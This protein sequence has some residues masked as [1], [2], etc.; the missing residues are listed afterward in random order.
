MIKVHFFDYGCGVLDIEKELGID[1][2][3][4]RFLTTNIPDL[5]LEATDSKNDM[6]DNAIYLF[7]ANKENDLCSVIKGLIDT[8]KQINSNMLYTVE[9]I[10]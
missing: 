8:H 1:I 7:S 4:D 5:S 9:I 10:N 2:D 3:I 6:E